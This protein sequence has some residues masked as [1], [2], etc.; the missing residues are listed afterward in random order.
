MVFVGHFTT[1]VLSMTFPGVLP[2]FVVLL[3]M[4]N[5]KSTKIGQFFFLRKKKKKKKMKKR[6]KSLIITIGQSWKPCNTVKAF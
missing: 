4:A 6:P 1:K 2:T 5:V 3:K